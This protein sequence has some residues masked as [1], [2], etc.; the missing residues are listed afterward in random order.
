MDAITTLALE[1]REQ[2]EKHGFTNEHDDRYTAGE[3]ERA[4]LSVLSE[5]PTVWPKSMQ[6]QLFLTASEKK[7]RDRLVTV[8]AMLVA[9]IERID[10][11]LA[12]A[13]PTEQPA[14]A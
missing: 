4:A 8:A 12:K 5:D 7:T 10:R 9:E 11:A 1:R 14:Q 6:I 3:L 13:V 2:Q